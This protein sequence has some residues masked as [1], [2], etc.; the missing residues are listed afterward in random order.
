MHYVIIGNKEKLLQSDFGYIYL[1]QELRHKKLAEGG[2][3]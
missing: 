1:P 3:A 2:V